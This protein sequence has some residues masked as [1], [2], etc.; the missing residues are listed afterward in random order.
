MIKVSTSGKKK[1]AQKYQNAYAFRANK[2]S[3]KTK[4][5]NSLPINGICKRC[6]DIIEWRKK[7]KKY[8]SLKTPKRCV[9]CE[10]KTVKE[11]YHILCNKCAKEKGVCA[12]CQGSED[13]VPSDVKSDKELL[14]EQQELDSILSSLPERKKRTY[15]R[16]LERGG[17]VSISNQDQEDDDHLDS[18]SDEETSDEENS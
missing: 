11:A 8:K 14:Q 4:I 9:C 2:N 3:K 12:K 18:V 17:E 16:Q 5:I 1:G 10:E 6:K 7:F 15:L 13:I